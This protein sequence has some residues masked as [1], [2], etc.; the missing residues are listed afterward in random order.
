VTARSWDCV[1]KWSKIE[2]LG[3]HTWVG[4]GNAERKRANIV[5][6]EFSP[7]WLGSFLCVSGAG[8]EVDRWGFPACAGGEQG[9][10]TSSVLHS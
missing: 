8:G 9:F 3:G 5:S 1:H 6:L 10:Q 7:S 2:P 4:C